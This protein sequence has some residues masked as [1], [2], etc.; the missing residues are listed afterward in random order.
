[1]SDSRLIQQGTCVAVMGLGV[2]GLAAV[3]YC[4]SCGAKVLVS[5]GRKRDAVDS[6]VL[7]FL[8]KNAIE[9]EAGEHTFHFL[10]QADVVI[11]SPGIPHDHEVVKQLHDAGTRVVGELA[12][13]APHLDIPV[14]AITGTN[15]KTTVTSLVGEILKE[16]GKNPFVGGNIGTPVLEFLANE[17]EAEV[18]VLEVSSFQ[19][20]LAGDFT[21]DVGVLLNITPDH[22]DRHGSIAS[23]AEAKMMLFQHQQEGQTAVISAEDR[24]CQNQMGKFKA[25]KVLF[26]T[27]DGCEALIFDSKVKTSDENGPNEY[28]LRGTALEN[29]I[30]VR[31]AAAAIL[32]TQAIGIDPKSI[33]QALCR[34]QPAPHRLQFVGQVGGVRFVNDSKATNTGAVIAALS[35][36]DSRVVLIAGGRDKGEKYTLLKELVQEKVR[37][38]IVIGEASGLIAEALTGCATIIR[39]TSLEDAV[40]KANDLANPGDTVLLSPACASF[41]MFDSYGHR[42]EVFSHA[43]QTLMAEQSTSE[44]VQ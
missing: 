35:Q 36:A 24:E 22:I 3:R 11:V 34:F 37:A 1:M 10:H 43:V 17:K 19:L 44:G 29:G 27:T 40:C 4:L 9:L 25:R 38:L 2:T 26:G 8:S 23:Y 5:E 6:E 30:G 20:Q 21:P 13:I 33:Q 7:T 14:I 42:G 31:N 32:A 39:A 16:A 41:D 12:V 28:D 15:G 18:M